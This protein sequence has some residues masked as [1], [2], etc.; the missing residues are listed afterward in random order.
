[1]RGSM[2]CPS[3]LFCLCNNLQPNPPSEDHP[4]NQPI[5]NSHFTTK[6]NKNQFNYD[7]ILCKK[8]NYDIIACTNY[9]K[10]GHVIK[11]LHN[12]SKFNYDIIACTNL[13]F[14]LG[15]ISLLTHQ[16]S[17]HMIIFNS[18]TTILYSPLLFTPH[19]LHSLSSSSLSLLFLKS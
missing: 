1:M 16:S 4:V 9:T 12:S 18:S 19:K 15:I 8:S 5:T 2:V 6:S 14:L 11:K 7:I 3:V 10:Y 13:H 17:L